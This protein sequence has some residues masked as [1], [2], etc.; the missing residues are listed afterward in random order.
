[1]VRIRGGGRRSGRSGRSG[2]IGGGRERVAGGEMGDEAV[3]IAEPAGVVAAAD[4]KAVGHVG[5]FAGAVEA[6]GE[7]SGAALAG[8]GGF[9]LAGELADAQ[10]GARPH[11]S[12]APVSGVE[13]AGLLG[14]GFRVRHGGEQAEGGEGQAESAEGALGWDALGNTGALAGGVGGTPSSAQ[15]RRLRGNPIRP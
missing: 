4:E 9:E 5:D 3:V 13:G 11:A 7:L 10:P 14:P 12:G 2:R 8:A 1:M 15:R 6:A